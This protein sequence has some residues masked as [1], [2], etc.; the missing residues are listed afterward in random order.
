MDQT[1]VMPRC[2]TARAEPATFGV[3]GPIFS[4][5]LPMANNP[6]FDQISLHENCFHETKF[7]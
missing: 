7:L 6:S 4:H 1:K 3:R 5:H 2:N